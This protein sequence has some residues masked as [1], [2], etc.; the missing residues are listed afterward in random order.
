MDVPNDWEDRYPPSNVI[1]YK[2]KVHVTAGKNNRK[3]SRKFKFRLL[4]EGGN[5]HAADITI[6]QLGN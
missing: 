4:T 6:M 5:G 3:K 2:E 1:M